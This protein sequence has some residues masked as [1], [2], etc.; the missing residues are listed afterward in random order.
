MPQKKTPARKAAAKTVASTYR[1]G[2]S[3][4]SLARKTGKSYG[5]VHNMLVETG[6]KRRSRGGPNHRGRGKHQS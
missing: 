1:K 3:I 6:T 5:T 4:R 2:A